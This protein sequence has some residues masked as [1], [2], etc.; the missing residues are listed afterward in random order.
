VKIPFH[1]FFILSAY[2]ENTWKVFQ[3]IWRMWFVVHKLSE[4]MRRV[5]ADME[6]RPKN[7]NDMK[8]ILDPV[9]VS[10]RIHNMNT[11]RLIYDWVL[12]RRPVNVFSVLGS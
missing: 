8:N 2:L 9:K 12:H 11:D 1:M 5:Y 3:L 4:N 6:R 10:I 7:K